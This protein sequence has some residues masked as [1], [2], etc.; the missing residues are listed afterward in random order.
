MGEV[1]RW[2]DTGLEIEPIDQS[3]V[4]SLKAQWLNIADEID[5]R[6]GNIFEWWKES[7]IHLKIRWKRY[8]TMMSY[9]FAKRSGRI[10][11]LDI[12]IRDDAKLSKI[13]EGLLS[14]ILNQKLEVMNQ[15]DW[16]QREVIIDFL[17]GET[18]LKKLVGEF[19]PTIGVKVGMKDHYYRDSK[20][21]LK[22][23]GVIVDKGW[24]QTIRGLSPL[25]TKVGSVLQLNRGRLVDYFE[26]GD[27]VWGDEVGKFSLWALMRTV[28]RLKKKLKEQGMPEYKLQNVRGK[29]YR[30]LD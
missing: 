28:S 29:G 25:E 7:Q 27:A 19:V 21:Y 12:M 17:V 18:V 11:K 4:A 16:L 10:I 13:L 30:L 15:Y 22:E 6:L 23:L 20:S 26:L 5:E 1:I 3:H 8:G 9:G 14:G 24:A 2:L